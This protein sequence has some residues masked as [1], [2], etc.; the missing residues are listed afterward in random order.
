MR[1]AELLAERERGLKA[2][3]SGTDAERERIARELHDG[4]GQQITDRT[5]NA[6]LIGRP[7]AASGEDQP[8]NRC[9]IRSTCRFTHVEAS[10]FLFEYRRW[11]SGLHSI[12]LGL[13]LR[14]GL[15]APV[16]PEIL[17]GIGQYH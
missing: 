4:I 12:E 14:T 13:T 15:E 6:D 11:V 9:S 10:L 1:A 17:L 8:G 7:C 2:V 16:R 3:V 5:Q